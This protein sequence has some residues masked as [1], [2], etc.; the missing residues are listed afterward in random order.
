[1]LNFGSLVF[2]YC[3]RNYFTLR[4]DVGPD[5]ANKMIKTVYTVQRCDY[6]DV[7]ADGL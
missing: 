7:P 1:M 5:H 3:S 4:S 6:D 2:L